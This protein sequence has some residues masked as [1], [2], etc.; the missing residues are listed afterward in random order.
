M[1]IGDSY[2]RIGKK[3]VGP[4]W[5]INSTGRPTEPTNLNP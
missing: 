5:D 2:G 4:E 3:I 1:K